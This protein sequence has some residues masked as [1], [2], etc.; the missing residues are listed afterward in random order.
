MPQLDAHAQ[1]DALLRTLSAARLFRGVDPDFIATL[2][3]HASMQHLSRGERLWARGEPA[4][5]F[6]VVI[7]GVLELQRAALGTETTLIG[8]FGPGESPAIPVTLE[9]RSFIADALAATPVLEIL[10][11]RAEPILEAMP[12]DPKLAMAATSAL[13]DHCRMMH[14][15]IDVLAAGAVP[16][17]LA[18]FLLELADRFGDEGLDGRTYVPLALSRTQIATYVGARVETVIR[19]CSTWQKQGLLTTTKDGF[20]LLSL[21]ALSTLASGSSLEG[22]SDSAGT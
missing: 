12:H 22:D 4:R 2:L 13:L 11:V 20:V 19:V 5:H 6:H 14:A 15:K 7:R 17:R 3:P 10:R 18:A 21:D 9:R 8:L 1:R 16:R